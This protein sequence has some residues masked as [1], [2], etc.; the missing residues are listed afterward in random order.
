MHA[1]AVLGLVFSAPSQ[2]IGLGKRLR[3]DLFCVEWDAKLQL[4]QSMNQSTNSE[5]SQQLPASVADSVA[6]CSCAESCSVSGSAADGMCI[7]TSWCLQR[8]SATTRPFTS[9]WKRFKVNI[10]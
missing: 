10:R 5:C 9:V 1:D 2:E 8:C 6:C 3:N 4:S 7:A